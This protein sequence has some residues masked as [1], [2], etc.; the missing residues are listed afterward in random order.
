[1]FISTSSHTRTTKA[2]KFLYPRET[3]GFI[4]ENDDPFN[5]SSWEWG[6]W[7]LFVLF[8]AAFIGF[9]LF[10]IF[11]NR[12]RREL[13]QRPIRGTAWLTP[14]SYRQSEQEY[15]GNS[16]RVVEDYVP[17]YT[18]Q[19]NDNDLGYYDQRGEFH[20]N[21]KSEYM[22][23]PDLAPR[24]NTDPNIPPPLPAQLRDDTNNSHIEREM[25]RPMYTPGNYYSLY[26]HEVTRSTITNNNNNS[27][28]ATS[29]NRTEIS[30]N[31]RNHNSSSE[32]GVV[33]DVEE[34]SEFSS[35]KNDKGHLS[36]A[37]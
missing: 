3:T 14:P 2:I 35:Y 10:T 33:Y 26:P 22:P 27:S 21:S 17:E 15:V 11:A 24:P 13:G 12:R 34:E 20:R 4:A 29:N 9:L 5:S 31:N 6:R 8:L 28:S 23:P 16:Q 19:T 18:A 25:V 1:M 30:N 7:I 32:I 36:K 37:Q